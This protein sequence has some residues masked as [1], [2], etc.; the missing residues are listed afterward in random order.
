M[1][2]K[3]RNTVETPKAG[4]VTNKLGVYCRICRGSDMF[5]WVTVKSGNFVTFFA[6]KTF[7][8]T[9]LCEGTPYFFFW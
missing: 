2:R 9:K 7:F 1:A 6:Q 3:N 4:Q 5:L 8:F